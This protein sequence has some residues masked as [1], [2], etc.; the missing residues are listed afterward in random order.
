MPPRNPNVHWLLLVGFV[1]CGISSATAAEMSSAEIQKR[2]QKIEQMTQIERDRLQRNWKSFDSLSAEQKQHY[3]QLHQSLEEDQATGNGQLN[4]MMQTYALWLQTLTPG[5]CADLRA[6]KDPAAKLEL[7]KKFKVEQD[8]RQEKQLLDDPMED[9]S[10][11]LRRRML[12]GRK[13]PWSGKKPL[14]SRELKVAMQALA[15]E[16]PDADQHDLAEW[17]PTREKWRYYG[18]IIDRSLRQANGPQEWPNRDQQQAISNVLKESEQIK[19]FD[20][21]K[22]KEPEL[23]SGYFH[24]IQES[25][26]ADLMADSEPYRPKEEE[27]LKL[28]EKLDHTEREKLSQMP[29]AEMTRDLLHRYQ[30]ANE[31]PAFQEFSKQRREF[32]ETMRKLMREPSGRG[33]RFGGPLGDS[34]R[35][36]FPPPDGPPPGEPPDD[37]EGERRPPP[38]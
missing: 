2:S 30:K 1:C 16:L 21:L 27:L 22:N 14:S 38:R 6:A 17:D 18:L 34:R 28:F 31:D 35:P 5:Q 25:L 20:L 32:L 15:R 8:E 4:E 13:K 33:R 10:F 7:V 24:L 12:G 29:F 9:P 37:R 19:R 11:L 3:R 36:P 26:F 23:R